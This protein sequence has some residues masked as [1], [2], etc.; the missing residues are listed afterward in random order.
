[1]AMTEIYDTSIKSEYYKT[2]LSEAWLPTPPWQEFVALEKLIL[3][4][5]TPLS[6][7]EPVVMNGGTDI[8]LMPAEL[9]ATCQSEKVAFSIC[10]FVVL[11]LTSPRL[12][13]GGCH[14]L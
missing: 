1:M 3:P 5:K 6:F 7:L 13:G 4:Q 9:F 11:L 10:A 14:P 12:T 2:R 8:G